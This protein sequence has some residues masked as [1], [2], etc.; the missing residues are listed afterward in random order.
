MSI[1]TKYARKKRLMYNVTCMSQ[2]TVDK[3]CPMT[4]KCKRRVILYKIL[5]SKLD[6]K[7]KIKIVEVMRL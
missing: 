4:K 1:C 7:Y 2:I 6:G 3:Y 5:K